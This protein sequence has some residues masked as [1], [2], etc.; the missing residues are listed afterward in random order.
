MIWIG[1]SRKF[2]RICTNCTCFSNEAILTQS[3]IDESD[4]LSILSLFKANTLRACL[5]EPNTKSDFK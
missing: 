3:L 1:H 2:W 5:M 4:G